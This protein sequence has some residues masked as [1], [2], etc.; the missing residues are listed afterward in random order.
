MHS[1]FRNNTHNKYSQGKM[2]V[3]SSNKRSKSIA[4]SDSEEDYFNRK[5]NNR[6]SKRRM[7]YEGNYAY[8]EISVSSESSKTESGLIKFNNQTEK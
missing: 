7:D 4:S 1:N 8:K 6:T 3:S 5:N 2:K